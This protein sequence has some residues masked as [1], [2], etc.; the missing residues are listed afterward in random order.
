MAILV[1]HKILNLKCHAYSLMAR[2]ALI[3]GLSFSVLLVWI[4]LFYFRK[5]KKTAALIDFNGAVFFE[6]FNIFVFVK[7]KLLYLQRK[8][9]GLM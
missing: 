6:N 5:N 3:K 7:Y 9:K 4:L 8:F 2:N 1:A